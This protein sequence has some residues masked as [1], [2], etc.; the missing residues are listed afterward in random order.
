ELTQRF[1]ERTGIAA[2]YRHDGPTPSLGHSAATQI[3]RI[4]QEALQNVEKHAQATQVCVESTLSADKLRVQ[5]RDDG[6]GFE[7]G[8]QQSNADAHGSE[9]GTSGRFGLLSLHERARLSGGVLQIQ[10]APD[11][12]T[13]IA[14]IIP[15][16]H[17]A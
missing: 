8:A 6:V 2:S 16:I 7:P 15:I 5:V 13:S 3:L 14:V 1:A 10:S 17:D 9:H 4:V 11:A 12:G